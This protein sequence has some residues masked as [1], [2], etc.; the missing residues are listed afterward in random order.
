MKFK[1]LK[2]PEK[3]P[4][5]GSR[6]GQDVEPTGY[7]VTKLESLIPNGWITGEAELLNPLYILVD[8]DTLVEWKYKLSKRFNKK[9]KQL[10]NLLIR[11]GYDGIVTR[12]K[13][14][15]TGEIIIFNP[16]KS[17]YDLP[18]TENIEE[19]Y[20]IR[21]FKSTLDETE[22]KWH[23]DEED[24]I[25]VCENDTDWLFQMDNEL[26][27]KINTN[28]PIFIPEGR[29]HRIIKGNGDLTVK[30]KKINNKKY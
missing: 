17:I 21:T 25:V 2:N 9:G 14:G 10:T 18:Y 27:V 11:Q 8:N 12:F 13:D 3:S 30:V 16:E 23:Y 22:L 26:P 29:Y 6:F 20:H 7:Y 1:F 15:T 28:I 19:G 24:R 5:F 4:N